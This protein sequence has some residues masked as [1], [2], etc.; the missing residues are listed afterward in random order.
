MNAD[1]PTIL[2]PDQYGAPFESG[3][4]GGKITSHGGAKLFAI[5]W[6]PKALGETKAI[7]LPSYTD[8]PNARSCVHSMDNTRAMAEAGS[9]L[10]QWIIGREINGHTDWCIPARDV[11][12]IA[13]RHLKPT[14]YETYTGYRDGDNPSSVPVGYPYSQGPVPVQTSAELFKAGADEAFEAQWYWS[15][16]QSSSDYAWGQN[17][18]YGRQSTNIKK[19]E[20]RARAVRLIR[21]D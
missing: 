9:P 13:Y 16:T 21:L 17:F 12:E 8:G 15:S 7:W 6:A 11:L 3:F 19:F 2:V 5:V 18:Y 14:T 4:Y 20:A 10:A 1:Q